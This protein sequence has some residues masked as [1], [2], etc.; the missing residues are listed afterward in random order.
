MSF[1]TLLDAYAQAHHY[2]QLL[3]C[4]LNT[5]A[6]YPSYYKTWP[7]QIARYGR[8]KA[9]IAERLLRAVAT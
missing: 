1:R 7:D 8:L 5:G 4:D 3:E 9:R 2:Q 6:N